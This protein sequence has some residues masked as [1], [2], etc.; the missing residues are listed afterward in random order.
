MKVKEFIIR[1]S[2]P[3]A[4]LAIFFILLSLGTVLGFTINPHLALLSFVGVAII[5]IV[6]IAFSDLTYICFCPNCRENFSK[7]DRFCRKCGSPT[8]IRRKLQKICG[9]GHRVADEKDEY[10]RCPK[11]GEALSTT[12]VRWDNSS[13]SSSFFG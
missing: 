7:R 1:N 3:P 9:N 6:M 13:K 11:C 2:D 10:K 8:E 4:A 5:I 12:R